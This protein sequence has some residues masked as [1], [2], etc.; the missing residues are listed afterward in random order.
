M[1]KLRIWDLPTRLFHWFLAA[2]VIGLLVTGHLGG[3]A[4]VWHFRLGYLVLTLLVFRLFW[5]FWGGFWSRWSQLSLRPQQML[6]YLK[7]HA[8]DVAGHN[9]LGS[10]SIVFMLCFLLFQVMT[11]L[12]SD[13]E[14]SNAGPLTALVS[15]QWV[16]WAT[17]WHK[18][19]GKL[20]VLLLVT[21]HILALLWHAFH[22]SSSLI[23]AMFHG[24]KTLPF[25]APESHDRVFSRW[26]ALV[27]LI[28][29]S[30]SVFALVT[31]SS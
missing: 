24:F 25:N 1:F 14:I 8:P 2:G 7:G 23:P 15:G 19:W 12:I 27:V 21:V 29:A 5:G 20:A 22:K 17:S 4:M 3:N 18:Q 16:S 10:L 28:A 13:D 26:L 31:W 9:P 30:M 6:S 11:G